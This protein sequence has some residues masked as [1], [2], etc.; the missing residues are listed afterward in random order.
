MAESLEDAL[1]VVVSEKLSSV[2]FVM[3]YW[4]L[5]FDGP[6]LTVLTRATVRGEDWQALDGDAEFRNR[7]CDCIGHVVSAADFRPGVCIHFRFEQGLSI[8][9]SLREQDYYCPEAIIFYPCGVCGEIY[10]V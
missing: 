7:L 3:D 9:V 4:Q 1:Q 2:T 6:L 5:A 10:V 8:E